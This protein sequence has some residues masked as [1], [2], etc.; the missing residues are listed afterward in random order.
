MKYCI[1][2]VLFISSCST[3][4]IKV[5]NETECSEVVP[6]IAISPA[7]IGDKKYLDHY[8]VFSFD[9]SPV[10]EPLNLKLVESNSSENMKKKATESFA[11]WRIRPTV[12]DGDSIEKKGCSY[13]YTESELV[14]LRQQ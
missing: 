7:N 8:F 5:S 1:V 9:I 4:N 12:I 10:G 13:K 2:F 6:M 3:T 14:R 11:K